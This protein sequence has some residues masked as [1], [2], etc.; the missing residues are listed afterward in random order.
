VSEVPAP[1]A[2]SLGRSSLLLGSGTLV[3]RV[4]GFAKLIILAQALGVA[5]SAGADSFAVANQLPTNL[6]TIIAGGVLTAT[7]VPAIVKSALHADGGRAYINKLMTITL[8]VLLVVTLA[9]TLCAPLLVGLYAHDWTGD[10][11]ALATALA[12]WCL[13]QIFFYGL[14][15]ILGEVLNA[16]GSFGPFTWA[17]ALNNVVAIAG[18]VAFMVL[19]GADSAGVRSVSDW[20]P[21]MITLLAGSATA[22]V[23]AQAMILTVFW[24]RIGLSY[25]PDFRWRGV[26]LAETGRVA[27]WTFG[28]VL[29]TQL[30]GIVETNVV[31]LASG[32]SASVFAMSTAWLIFMLPH[33]IITVSLGTVYFTRMSADAAAHN[34]SSLTADTSQALRHIGLLMVWSA[35]GMI[36]VA[37]PLARLF[38]TNATSVQQLAL[39]IMVLVLALPAF[40]LLFVIFRVFLAIG[41]ARVLFFLTVFQVGLFAILAACCSALPL[42]FIT[43]GVCA[44]LSLAVV[45]QCVLSL[46][47]LHRELPGLDA[48]RLRRSGV[49]STVAGVVAATAGLGVGLGLGEFSGGFAVASAGGAIL[50]LPVLGIAVTVVFVLVLALLRSHELGEVVRTVRSRIRRS[51]GAGE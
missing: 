31:A 26:G 41:K 10:Q 43:F 6:Y 27:G 51:R 21:E 18:L 7:L 48:R 4:L 13:P 22:G 46:V 24:R 12:Y 19:F 25:R 16:R 39:L 47:L 50:S 23:A 49:T 42:A 17:P 3:S 40:S 2:S 11:L 30:G 20:T 35:A 29:V 5:A 34:L 8:V 45:L 14:Y 44:S 38:T 9:A 36:S 37:F 33:S 15:T 32:E 1:R 28:I